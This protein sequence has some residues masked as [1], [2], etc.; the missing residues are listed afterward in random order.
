MQVF[1]GYSLYFYIIITGLFFLGTNLLFFLQ[2]IKGKRLF[3]VLRILGFVIYGFLLL[4]G[5][6]ALFDFVTN[7]EKVIYPEAFHIVIFLILFVVCLVLD[8]LCKHAKVDSEFMSAMRHN[9]R[10]FLQLLS[11]EALIAT[12]CATIE[13]LQ[14]ILIQKYVGYAYATLLIYY[15]VC[16][17]FSMIVIAVRKAFTTNPY[18]NIPIPFKKNSISGQMG[19]VEY[20]EKN[21]GISMRSLWSAKFIRE[22]APC[23][24]LLSGLFLWLSTSIVQV[25]SYQQAAVYR[26]GVLQNEMLKPGMHLVLPYPFDK[27]EIYDTEILN[28]TTIGF[29]AEENANNIW[30]TSHEGEEYKLLLGSGDELVSINL[31]LEYKISDLQAYLKSTAKPEAI[32]EAI[33]Y[34]L[35]T[36]RTI[37]TDLSTLLS[38]DREEF[39]NKFQKELEVLLGEKQ[40]GLEVVSVVLE[41]IHPPREIA[42]VYQATVSA[43]IEAQATIL[44]AQ[45]D[46]EV[47]LAEAGMAYD[48]AVS[49]AQSENVKSVAEAKSNVAEFMASLESYKANKDSYTFQKYLNAVREA[50]GNANLVIISK[51]IDESALFFGNFSGNSRNSEDS[52]NTDENADQAE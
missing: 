32:L 51:D 3:L 48:K 11:L 28:K 2:K 27:V 15:A 35:V 25:E 20:L 49:S 38:T 44:S 50:Y 10:L 52:S 45:A 6:A 5:S 4:V 18:L 17:L 19:F 23:T 7:Y 42:S 24:L 26:F 8:K 46:A 47:T 41:S 36:D 33:S 30:T 12:V 39:S 14:L 16:V 43:E 21:T 1:T 37:H 22:I 29:R 13:S 40:V 9:N 31:R 34:E